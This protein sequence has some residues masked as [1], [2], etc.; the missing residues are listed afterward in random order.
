MVQ[1]AVLRRLTEHGIAAAP[2]KGPDLALRVHGDLGM[3]PC[4][5]VD[6]IVDPDRLKEAVAVVQM[7][8]YGEPPPSDAPWFGEL[9]ERLDHPADTM[10][11]VEVHWRAEWYS[12]DA[13]A[14][15]LARSAL[16]RSD[17]EL[18]GDGRRLAPADELAILLLVYARDS[19]VGM[20]LPADIAAWWDRYG[21]DVPA[22][23]L[24]AIV[25]VDPPLALPLATAAVTCQ[26]LVGLP[27]G[28]LLALGPARGARAR[29]AGRLADPF[30]DEPPAHRASALV[31]G[32]LSSRRKIPAFLR[33]RVLLPAG[34][35]ALRYGA[36][37]GKGSAVRVRLL[38]L[39]HPF[40]Q[41]AYFASFA[42]FPPPRPPLI[43]SESACGSG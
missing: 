13:R 16:E 2:L 5:D 14:G 34:H 9:H 39:Q 18:S 8:G 3:R 35:T 23:A 33:R 42:A 20:R 30:L 17:P 38:Q 28:R 7:L 31:D 41:V 15:G 29:L 6:V 43:Q 21:S 24:Q 36:L 10:P 19:L 11:T 25:E 22:G 37:D 27:A 40:R 4:M 32:L 1:R 26:R 12:K